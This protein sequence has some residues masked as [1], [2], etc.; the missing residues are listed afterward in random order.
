V[1]NI[2][3]DCGSKGILRIRRKGRRGGMRGRS[4]NISPMRCNVF[5]R[6]GS[7]FAIYGEDDILGR[8]KG[9]TTYLRGRFLQG[10]A[11][12]HTRISAQ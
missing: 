7:K 1:Y 12:K 3:H 8:M 11:L 5:A 10:N 9:G 4:L 2:P 6:Y